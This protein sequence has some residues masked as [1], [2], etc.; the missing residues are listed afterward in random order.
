[1][2]SANVMI[3]L[4]ACM[5]T[6]MGEQGVQERDENATLWGPSVE[7]QRGE[8]L[9]PTFTTWGQ[10]VKRSRTQLHQAGSRP[11]LEGTMVLNAEL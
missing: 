10:P 6:V 5:A 11:S 4:E 3:E 8:M 7:D 2:S 9:F 1:M